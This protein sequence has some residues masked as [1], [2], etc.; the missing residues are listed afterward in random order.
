L[1]V[2]V[3]FTTAIWILA[4]G[5][6]FVNSLAMLTLAGMIA[7]VLGLRWPAIGLV[8]V[9]G[10]CG[11]D[12]FTRVY[13]MTGGLLRWNTFNYVLLIA[14]IYWFLLFFRASNIHLKFLILLGVLMVAELGFSANVRSGI[15]HILYFSSVFG[16]FV[17]FYRG[18]RRPGMWYF[19]AVS[20]GCLTGV[21]GFIYQ[22]SRAGGLERFDENG[23]AHCFIASLVP[24]CF[25][26]R[27]IVGDQRRQ[28]ILALLIAVNFCW[29]FL[30]GSRGGTLVG[31]CCVLCFMYQVGSTKTT[32][33]LV[34]IAAVIGGAIMMRFEDKLDRMVHRIDKM[35]NTEYSITKRTHGRYDLAMGAFQIFLDN[36]LGVGTGGYAKARAA[37]GYEGGVFEYKQ[38]QE[39]AAHSAWMKVL[40]ENGLPGFLLLAAYVGS[41]AVVGWNQRALGLLPLGLLTT[42]AISIFYLASEFQP[43]G[44]WM[45]AAGTMVVMHSKYAANQQFATRRARRRGRSA[46]IGWG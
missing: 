18:T 12:S 40:A 4:L 25:A 43:K 9:A 24:A 44:G 30:T 22:L 45:L 33:R 29:V 42:L 17:Y 36:P 16:L 35:S 5:I 26:V 10:L 27:F 28:T 8:G 38:G 39:K 21:G 7:A 2:V 1:P 20:N 14:T 11:L 41:F 23:L 31:I 37:A 19:V 15:Q 3:G 13:L 6:G 46:P 32:F 34:V